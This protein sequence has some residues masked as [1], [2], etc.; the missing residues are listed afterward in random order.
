[1]GNFR[2]VRLYYLS[3]REHLINGG[4]DNESE[5]NSG[6][7]AKPTVIHSPKLS[8]REFSRTAAEAAPPPQSRNTTLNDKNDSTPPPIIIPEIAPRF[9]ESKKMDVSAASGQ[10]EPSPGVLKEPNLTTAAGGSL[11]DVEMVDGSN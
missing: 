5:V 8:Q 7:P 4:A 3:A 11:A 1:M 9:P 6:A 2:R 10:S